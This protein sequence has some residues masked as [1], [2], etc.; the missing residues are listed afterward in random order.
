[1]NM[2][3][4]TSEMLSAQLQRPIP[5]ILVTICKNDIAGLPASDI[6]RLIG[7]S[8][9]EVVESQKTDDYRDIRLLMGAAQASE[10]VDTDFSWDGIESV[11]VGKLYQ[12]AKKSRDPE[13][14]LKVAAVAN[15]AQRRIGSA[16]DKVLDQ[17]DANPVVPL[18]LTQRIIEQMNAGGDFTRVTERQISVLDGSAKNPSFSKI[19]AALGVNVPT[20]RNAD[21]MKRDDFD[22]GD[23]DG[24]RLG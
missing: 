7:V 14:L 5:D 2:M 3:K 1:M 20:P 12:E 21:R 24:I 18:R 8:E 19:D 23:L 16:R 17:R 15:K 10:M 22:L 13:F 6:A 9:N 11:A 4:F